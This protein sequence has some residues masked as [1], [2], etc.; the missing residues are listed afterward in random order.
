MTAPESPPGDADQTIQQ[1]MLKAMQQEVAKRHSDDGRSAAPVSR[2][3][4]RISGTA[5]VI[6]LGLL[7]ALLALALLQAYRLGRRAR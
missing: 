5:S 2:P 7:A 1:E 4:V 6:L 3:P